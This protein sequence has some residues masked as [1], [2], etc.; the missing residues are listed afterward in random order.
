MFVEAFHSSIK[1]IHLILEVKNSFGN[2]T[3]TTG[4]SKESSYQKPGAPTDRRHRHHQK[5]GKENLHAKSYKAKLEQLH[6][7]RLTRCDQAV[8]LLDMQ[9]LQRVKDT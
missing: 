8:K 3:P 9:R 1:D 6:S 4:F 7:A 5:E 2:S